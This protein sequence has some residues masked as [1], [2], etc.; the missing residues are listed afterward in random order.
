L[1]RIHE[2]PRAEL[3]RAADLLR[4]GR[5]VA[6]PTETVYGLGANALDAEALARI[7][8]A[9]GRP[10]TSPL[11]VHIA[12]REMLPRV[13]A[14]WSEQA[15]ILTTKFWPGPLTLVLPKQK[16]VP[17]LVTAGLPTV[18]VRMPSHPV[19]LALIRECDLPLAAPSANR[20]TQ[21]SPTTA[22]H[23]RQSLGDR[24]D[25]ILDGGSCEVGIE[26]TVLSL[27]GDVPTLLRP[28]GVSRSQIEE[29]IGPIQM[30]T[31]PVQGPHVSPGLHAKHYSPHT[32]LVLSRNGELPEAGRGAYL[33]LSRGPIRSQVQVVAMPNT[34]ES[35]AS[36]LYKTL[37]DLD[38]KGLD[39]IAVERPPSMPEWD[40]VN[41]RLRRAAH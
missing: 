18:G 12:L 40:A 5:L 33:Q 39:W 37:H 32:R 20:F 28:G 23:V 10:R 29:V 30:L 3:R 8:E 17:D 9:K 31:E 24:V 1:K 26:S 13:V 25:F 21:L 19:A 14:H 15:D 27:A 4:A 16:A 6:F 36:A 38:S 34:P 11:I 7:Y 2:V 41:D 35:Y 22:E